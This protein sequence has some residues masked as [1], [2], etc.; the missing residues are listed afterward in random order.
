MSSVVRG[1]DGQF[2]RTDWP[3]PSPRLCSEPSLRPAALRK[4]RPGSCPRRVPITYY[5]PAP[6]C[7]H[8]GTL[9]PPFPCWAR[10]LHL[11]WAQPTRPLPWTLRSDS[12]LPPSAAPRV[13]TPSLLGRFFPRLCLRPYHQAPGQRLAHSRPSGQ[14]RRIH[15]WMDRSQRGRGR[16]RSR[17][18]RFA[19][20]GLHPLP[21]TDQHS[22][23]TGRPGRCEPPWPQAHSREQRAE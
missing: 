18:G 9:A 1:C 22:V 12:P 23:V 17:P 14:I 19:A 8:P 5:W 20:R 7:P 10:P 21:S 3:P 4:P 2:W 13:Q 11:P 6:P 15:R 16:R